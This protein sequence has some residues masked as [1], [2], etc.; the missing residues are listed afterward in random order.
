MMNKRQPTPPQDSLLITRKE[1]IELL[2]RPAGS[3]DKLLKR[4]PDFPEKISG[5]FYS[6]KAVLEWLAAHN[7]I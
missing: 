4:T 5:G 7:L 6:R 3:V 1:I 2:G